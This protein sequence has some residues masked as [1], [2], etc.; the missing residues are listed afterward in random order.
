MPK[1]VY[2][3]CAEGIVQDKRTSLVSIFKVTEQVTLELG[4]VPAPDAQGRGL[5]AGDKFGF[6]AVS[7]WRKEG[8]DE[9][10]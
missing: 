2:I 1:P 4:D 9:G 10:K 8:G 7:V 3:I 5:I 6:E